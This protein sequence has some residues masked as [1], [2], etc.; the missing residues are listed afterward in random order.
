MRVPCTY[1]SA[2]GSLDCVIVYT[3]DGKETR[4][5]KRETDH[6]RMNHHAPCKGQ[7]LTN[8]RVPAHNGRAG[9]AAVCHR[10]STSN[11]RLASALQLLSLLGDRVA[12]DAPS[13]CCAPP[14]SLTFLNI[15][16]PSFRVSVPSLHVHQTQSTSRIRTHAE[17]TISYCTLR[18]S[19]LPVKQT[20]IV[21]SLKDQSPEGN[22]Q[23][24]IVALPVVDTS[25]VARR[26]QI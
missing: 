20:R 2:N 6:Y 3:R 11:F 5:G 17:S 15:F 8:S 22:K 13:C 1:L 18:Y 10:S 24:Q 21:G 19:T 25:L 14:S 26:Q 9:R 7:S 12:S 16:F 23:P 4:S